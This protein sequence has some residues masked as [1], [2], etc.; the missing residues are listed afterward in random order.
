MFM[1]VVDSSVDHRDILDLRLREITSAAAADVA[2][3][4]AAAGQPA[5]TAVELRRMLSAA[6]E[7]PAA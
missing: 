1:D 4:A 7:G 5:P 2:A 6:W 3:A